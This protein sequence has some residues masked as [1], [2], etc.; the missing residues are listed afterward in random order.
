MNDPFIVEQAALWAKRALSDATISVEQRIERLYVTAFGRVASA[1]E[2]SEATS[3]LKSQL[4]D[5]SVPRQ[6]AW[7]NLCHVLFNI[8]EFVFIE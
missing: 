8:K 7:S 1:A 5:P 4:S 3:F 2:I 6:E